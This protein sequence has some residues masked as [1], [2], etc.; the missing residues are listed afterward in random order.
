MNEGNR[1]ALMVL[2]T[3]VF[4]WNPEQSMAKQAL[5]RSYKNPA[6]SVGQAYLVR[7]A[8]NCI[9]LLPLHVAKETAIPAFLSEGD[10][11]LGEAEEIDDLG[12][13]SAV[14]QVTGHITKD[15]GASI[16][17]ISRAVDTLLL[18]RGL[19]TL[20]SVNSD[21][22]LANMA[23]TIVDNDGEKYLRVRPS[24]DKV[25]I[26]KGHSGSLVLVGGRPVGMLLSVTARHGVGK[27]L[28]F[29]KLLESAE[30]HM[31]TRVRFASKD[32]GDAA[33]DKAGLDLAAAAN[34]GSVSG[35]NA[36][37]VDA[38]HR[39]AN[40]V[41]PDTAPYWR[42]S[43]EKWPVDIEID[44]AG[45]KVVISQI[46]LDGR[47]MPSVDELPGQVAIF[48][49]VSS[50]GRRW[51][52]LLSREAEF[53]S[54]GIAVFSIAPTWARQVKISIGGSRGEGNVTGLRR[55]NISNP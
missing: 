48:V 44:L 20:R 52:S 55:I 22:T 21:G 42:A 40:L 29:D 1:R 8:D 18:N 12:D 27:V 54:T 26:R 43:V 9:A 28:R 17:T 53:D 34:G 46:T 25:Q 45:D 16:A 30:A 38:E 37:P 49:N 3:A 15:C 39:P 47:N 14:A 5:V 36:V 2:L 33:T 35:W 7:Y 32:A 10:S 13:D 6:L 31:A 50:D 51:R 41:G 24:N 11:A 19:A 4:L 23:V